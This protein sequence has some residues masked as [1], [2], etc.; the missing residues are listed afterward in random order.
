MGDPKELIRQ[1]MTLAEIG[2]IVS[3]S[4]EFDEV[5][6]RFALA[7]QKL[8]PF[9]RIAIV[10]LEADQGTLTYQ[11]VKG[12]RVP[13]CEVGDRGKIEG[14]LVEKILKTRKGLLIQGK[15]IERWTEQDERLFQ[16]L[17]AGLRS[18]ISAPL[19]FRGEVI[20]IL[21][22][23]AKRPEAYTPTHLK[24]AEEIGL[25]ISGAL[26][27]AKLFQEHRRLGER[28]FFQASLLDQV[29]NGVIAT[30]LKRRILFWN[31][32]A[33]RLF[34]WKKEEIYQKEITEVLSEESLVTLKQSG[35]WEGECVGIRKDG[36]TFPVHLTNSIFRDEKGKIRGMIFVVNDMTDRK[37]IEDLLRASEERYRSLFEESKDAIFITSLEGRFIDINP[38]AVELFGY[39]SKEELQQVDIARDLHLDPT[40]RERVVG[41]L[42]QEGFVKDLELVLKKKGGERVTVLMTATTMRNDR[43]EIV[44]YRG[45]LRDVTERKAL[46][47]QL[48]QSQKMEAIGMLAGGIAHDF[49]NLLMVIQGNVELGLMNLDPSHPAYDSLL[50]IEESTQKARGLTRQLLAFGRRQVLNPKA[51]DVAE[52]IGNLSK[53]VSRLI[54]EDIELRIEIKPG[55]HLIYADPSALDQVLMNLIV[56]ARDAMPRGGVLTLQ[57]LNVHLGEAF[58][59]QHP[60][61]TPGDYVQ[62]S[63]I[64]TGMG[65]DEATCLRIF[66]PFFTTRE[67][68]SGLGLSVVYGIVKQHNGHIFVSSRPGEGTRFDLYFPVHREALP[69]ETVESVPEEIPRGHETILIAED[70]KEIRELLKVLLE[71]LGYRVYMAKDGEEAVSV[72]RAYREEIDLVILDAVMP[73]MNGPQVYEEIASSSDLPC[74]FLSGYSEE[75]VERYFDQSLNIPILHKPVSL[76]ELGLKVR[77]I[78]DGAPKSPKKV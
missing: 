65:M 43:G 6:E 8:I 14:P 54:G 29:R 9:D 23:R 1:Y 24:L 58:C 39:D 59:H 21:H 78:L 3:S 76:R 10:L 35:Y 38:A 16:T 69:P 30:D 61:V 32:F 31:P 34:L 17:K 70:E 57:A 26:G 7:V 28:M 51:L 19:I 4:L 71:G 2:R 45:I 18:M 13:Q 74:L 72:F 49:N 15:E 27:S 37:R 73:K 33:E 11:Y 36:T 52:V 50:K 5:C 53:M 40:G 41:L 68:G 44:G 63:V 22:L 77:E 20:G 47:E 55:L 67:K 66:E 62:I 75:I 60:F 12:V 64:D 46:E 48:V 42:N 25:Q 56:N